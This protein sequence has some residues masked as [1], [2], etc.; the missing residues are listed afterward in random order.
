VTTAT[1]KARTVASASKGKP[2]VWRL[3]GAQGRTSEFAVESESVTLLTWTVW[4]DMNGNCTCHG[5]NEG[6]RC[7]P[8][9]LYATCKHCDAV[10]R[11]LR[12]ER[13]N[14]SGL[15]LESLFD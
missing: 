2:T 13:R 10:D 15:T 4:V 14:L 8:F 3:S 11:L 12:K 7:W 5:N 6:G 1:T 9:R